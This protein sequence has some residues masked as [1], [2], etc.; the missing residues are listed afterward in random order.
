MGSFLALLG[1]LAGAIG[2]GLLVLRLRGQ[3]TWGTPRA[4]RRPIPWPAAPPPPPPPP[5]DSPL[6]VSNRVA[7]AE[8]T[9]IIEAA[10]REFD[11]RM[12]IPDPVPP[13]VPR[14]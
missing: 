9:R 8:S 14:G 6:V 10:Q 7:M 2:L 12:T 3:L 13:E 5:P 11:R 4:M 1:A